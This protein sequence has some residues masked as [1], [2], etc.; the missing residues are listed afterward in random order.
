MSFRSQL[1][2]GVFVIGIFLVIL[3]TS[4]C[5]FMGCFSAS[6]DAPAPPDTSPDDD[7][8]V[9]T[10]PDETN[11][12]DE[13]TGST[14][15]YPAGADEDGIDAD[16]LTNQHSSELNSVDSYTSTYQA[17]F[18]QEG[19]NVVVTQRAQV[20]ESGDRVHLRNTEPAMF[21]E[22]WVDGQTVTK[23]SGVTDRYYSQY[24]REASTTDIKNTETLRQLLH[25]GVFTDVSVEERED[26]L[27]WF[28]YTATELSTNA[29]HNVPGENIENYEAT[30]VLTAD[31]VV[32]EV[33]MT[34]DADVSG[35]Q[36]TVNIEMTYEQFGETTVEEPDWLSTAES[37]ATDLRTSVN[38]DTSTIELTHQGGTT[39]PAETTVVLV[40]SNSHWSYTTEQSIEQGD[41]VYLYFDQ[42][43]DLQLSRT[44][45]SADATRDFT[46]NEYA[47]TGLHDNKE[48]F[49]GLVDT[50]G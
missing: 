21:T 49:K 50:S 8:N 43:Q 39:V 24:D 16:T 27:T 40:T 42:N 37:E 47:I 36:M 12:T 10:T 18:D 26:D 3:V 35:Q 48:L 25:S 20:T 46:S 13:N 15:D 22:L 6:P 2:I 23:M 5:V 17:E 7:E 30:V 4:G 32:R 31:G 11:N 34:Y 28:T 19:E 41:T 45:P 44:Q 38:S 29:H 14:I 9:S 33:S 1:A